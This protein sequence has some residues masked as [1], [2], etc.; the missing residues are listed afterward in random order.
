MVSADWLTITLAMRPGCLYTFM[1]YRGD[2]IYRSHALNNICKRKTVGIGQEVIK[3]KNA[4]RAAKLLKTF[5]LFLN[6][7]FD[8]QEAF[9]PLVL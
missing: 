5:F 4:R 3:G 6:A 8:K 1:A 9:K 2:V 7:T